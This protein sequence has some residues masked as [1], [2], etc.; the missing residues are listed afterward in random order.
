MYIVYIKLILRKQMSKANKPKVCKNLPETELWPYPPNSIKCLEPENNIS[1]E[2][3]PSGKPLNAPGAKA[4]SGKLQGWLLLSGFSRALASV[5]EV[6]TLGANKYTR[7]G[8]ETVENG[9]ERYMEA[10]AR[11]LFKLGSGEILDN[12][13]GGIGTKHK[14]QMI[15]NLLASL[16]LELRSENKN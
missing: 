13:P 4:D 3:D 7:G 11:H 9:Q 8:W 16:E 15:W 10:F 14:A 6:T 12:G 1:A 2:I 5:A